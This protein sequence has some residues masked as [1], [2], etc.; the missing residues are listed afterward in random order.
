LQLDIANVL[1]D[2]GLLMTEEPLQTMY[3][4]GSDSEE[5]EENKKS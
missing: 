4:E 2:K 5:E 1:Y 3:N